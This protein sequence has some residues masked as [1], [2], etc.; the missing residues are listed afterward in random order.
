MRILVRPMV[1]QLDSVG[2]RIVGRWRMMVG[3]RA[4]LDERFG[5]RFGHNE[6]LGS[7]SCIGATHEVSS[8]SRLYYILGWDEYSDTSLHG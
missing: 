5:G 1:E 8:F 3:I 6:A 7:E 2:K 4:A